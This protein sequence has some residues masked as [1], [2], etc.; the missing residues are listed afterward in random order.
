MV[1]LI[2]DPNAKIY[3]GEVTS[4][5]VTTPLGDTEIL[6]GHALFSSIVSGK[7]K[8]KEK[9]GKQVEIDLGGRRGILYTDGK[10]ALILIP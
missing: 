1:V 6:E 8:L 9:N 4:I 2:Q 7:V 10:R 5:Y 3:Q